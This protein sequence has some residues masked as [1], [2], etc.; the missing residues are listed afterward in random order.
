MQIKP[1]KATYPFPTINPHTIISKEIA[2]NIGDINTNIIYTRNIPTERRR[3][4]FI[5]FITQT[6]HCIDQHGLLCHHQ[7][8]INSRLTI[9]YHTPTMGP[10][11]L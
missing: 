8:K 4:V 10:L 1:P 9:R 3:I 2:D 11:A 6:N 5:L 7:I